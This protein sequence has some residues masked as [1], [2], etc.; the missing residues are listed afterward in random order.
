MKKSDKGFS[1]FDLVI[2]SC[3]TW[4]YDN[5]LKLSLKHEEHDWHW[6]ENVNELE[7]LLDKLQPK[8]IFFLHWNWIVPE[9]IWSKIECVCFHMTDVP[10]GRG[11][12]P[13]QNL[14]KDSKTSTKLTALKMVE[15]MDA[16]PV[17]VKKDL[18]LAGRAEEIYMRAGCLSFEIIEWMIGVFPEP[19]NQEG[20]VTLFTR[21]TPEQSLM[22][23]EGQ[24]EDLYDHIRMLDAKGYPHAFIDHGEY[25]YEFVNASVSDEAI[26]AEVV[27]RKVKPS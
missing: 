11:G 18:S 4:H 8:Y 19:V 17:Y 13:L 16:G 20:E 7:T 3:K 1:K 2:A 22:P 23:I 9:R 27:I 12:S 24:I 10:Y 6:V 26:K 25:R 15:E 21:R 5:F 14:I